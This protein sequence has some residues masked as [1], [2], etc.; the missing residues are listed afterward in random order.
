[1]LSSCVAENSLDPIPS[2][3][4]PIVSNAWKIGS[5]IDKNGVDK[6]KYFGYYKFNFL[7]NGN[8][9]VLK[10]NAPNAK[11]KWQN[12]IDGN[13][14]KLQINLDFQNYYLFEELNEDWEY[15]SKDVAKITLI[16]NSGNSS[17]RSLILI[18]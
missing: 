10:N 18:K 16:K 11:G 12:L 1:M 8:I 3:E 13:K 5:L 9:E 15:L 6:T 17:S 14:E 7:E 4:G 2:G